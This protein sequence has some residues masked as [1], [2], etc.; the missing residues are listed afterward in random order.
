MRIERQSHATVTVVRGSKHGKNGPGECM[1]ETGGSQP[2]F[3]P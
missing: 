1:T 3:N 2:P